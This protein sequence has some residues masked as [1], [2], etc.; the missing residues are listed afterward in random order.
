MA[1]PPLPP[2]VRNSDGAGAEANRIFRLVKNARS[3]SGRVWPFDVTA[4]ASRARA[5]SGSASDATAT[6]FIDGFGG[7]LR[8]KKPREAPDAPSTAAGPASATTAG[9]K[10]SDL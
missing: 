8:L 4:R 10:A 9:S 2:P 1:A 6:G 7:R 3:A 5:G